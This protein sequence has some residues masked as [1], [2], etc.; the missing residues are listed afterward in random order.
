MIFL[1]A[2][3]IFITPLYIVRFSLLTFPTNLLMLWG[4][5]VWIIFVIKII[6]KKQSAS[7]IY[8]IRSF[9]KKILVLVGLFFLAGIITLFTHGFD[10]KK[11]GQFIVLFLQPISLFFIFGFFGT[12]HPK[13]KTIFINALY[14]LLGVMG[15]YAVVQYFTLLGLPSQFWG[16]SEEPKRAIGFFVHPNFYA[17]FSAPLLA[18]LIPDMRLK[19]ERLRD[20]WHIVLLWLFGLA[21]LLFVLVPRRLAWVGS[22]HIRLRDRRGR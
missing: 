16:N 21:G 3:S 11:L 12:E 1:L 10:Q 20:E 2:I 19:I 7:F 5:L 9:D 6:T 15:A 14:I 4:I 8:F 13:Q 22:G 17:L 18:F